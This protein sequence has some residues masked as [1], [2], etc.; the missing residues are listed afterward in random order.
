MQVVFFGWCQLRFTA[1]VNVMDVWDQN[2]KKDAWLQQSHSRTFQTKK[3]FFKIQ[4]E[5]VVDCGAS[6]QESSVKNLGSALSNCRKKSYLG[7]SDLVKCFSQTAMSNRGLLKGDVVSARRACC[8]PLQVRLCSGGDA[9]TTKQKT[10]VQNFW[11]QFIWL[12]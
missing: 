2:L 9:D 3:T 4:S 7:L 11:L 8:A 10:K 6:L 5:K 12:T 1:V